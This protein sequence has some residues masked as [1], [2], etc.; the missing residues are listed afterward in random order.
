MT[1]LSHKALFEKLRDDTVINKCKNYAHWTL[2]K[3]MADFTELQSSQGRVTVERDYQEIGAL[4]TNNLATKL[5]RLLFPNL[6]F[7]KVNA[8]PALRKAATDK[9]IPE[10]AFLSGL[11]KAES[12]AAARVFVNAGYAQLIL[13][14]LH[15]IV[16]GNVLLHRDSKAGTFHTYGLQ[17]FATRRDG[18]GNNLDTVLREFTVVEGLPF[19]VQQ[20][21][22][23]SNPSKYSRPEQTV[24]VYTRI[25]RVVKQA[26]VVIEVS[27]E[28]DTIPVGE[29]ASYPEHLCPWI[30]P[31]WSLIHGEHY[32]RG[33]VEDYAGGFAKLSDVSEAQALY[34][35]E[36]MRVLHLVSA[37]SGTDIDDLANAES[38]EYV[39]GDPE[40]VAVHETGDANKAAQVSAELEALT[41]RLSRAFMYTGA[42]RDSERTT[43][44]ELQR[45]SLEAD[46][47]LGGT[48]SSLSSSVQVN[49]AHILLTEANESTLAGIIS[50]DV[51]L[52]IIAGIPALGRSTDVQNLLMASQEILA[53]APLA[54]LDKRI[55][56]MKLVD[57]IFAGR[58]VD[59]ATVMYDEQQQ[60]SIN[61][62]DRQ[63][64]AGQQQLL[65]AA[66]AAD[67]IDSIENLTQGQQ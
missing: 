14:L 8:S 34:L 50:G 15:L 6:P 32:G 22:R 9:G 59:P 17:S 37:S 33:M 47:S 57:V 3:L 55:D 30:C 2:P 39:R 31:T 1:R 49:L 52:E 12:D 46:N 36:M 60:Q 63:A 44:Y 25:H 18:R 58:S 19:D 11:A 21:L 56:I 13:M 26:G 27:Q 23:I 42:A 35:I 5:A 61:D 29:T 67:Q 62:A 40:T 20:A 7:F 51:K 43:A 53:A 41:M 64:A 24:E 45:E 65:S 48:Y 16:T 54:Q 38:G 10:Q 66:N 4:L 28:V